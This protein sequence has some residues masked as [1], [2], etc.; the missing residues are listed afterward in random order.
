MN[1]KRNSSIDIMRL[2]FASAVVLGHTYFFLDISPSVAYWIS[3][4]FPRMAVPFFFCISGYYFNKALLN[5]KNNFKK[6]I[7]G[8]LTVYVSWTLL[9]YCLSFVIALKDHKPM[10]EFLLQRIQ[11][12]LLDGSFYHFWYF[13]A[14]IY[15]ILI[16]SL[17]YTLWKKKGLQILAYFS[18]LLYLFAFLGTEYCGLGRKIPGF[19]RIYDLACYEVLR[20]IF[21]MGIPFFMIGYFLNR[22]KDFWNKI[23]NK[24]AGI[25]FFITY[26]CYLGE[27][28]YAKLATSHEIASE[29]LAVSFF[30]PP[31]LLIIFVNLLKHPLPKYYTQSIYCRKI[32]N[33]MYY[34]H[35]LLILIITT[36]ASIAGFSISESIVFLIVYSIT[37]AGG[38]ICC[39][40]DNKLTR[41]LV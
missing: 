7:K 10:K 36:A 14:L 16:T 37:I 29:N 6:Q 27:A 24:T 8:I 13:P 11:Y 34:I 18:I 33:F 15:T 19:S 5:G 28:M 1:Q 9:Y 38:F 40:Y 39:K 35:P 41:L 25:L 20:G 30:L 2:I 22:Y 4:V 17:I 23:S 12:F 21:C 31:A 26:L 3:R 32:S